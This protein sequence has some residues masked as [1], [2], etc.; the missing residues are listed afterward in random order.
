MSGLRMGGI[1]LAIVGVVGVGV[2]GV[3][4]FLS[5]QAKS[6]ID[7]AAT[8]AQGQVTGITQKDAY[9]LDA[10]VRTDATI[11]NLGFVLGGALVGTGVVLFLVGG[12]ASPSSVSLAPVGNGVV[13]S[14]TW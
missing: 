12:S 1:A 2:G 14:G 9:A 5:N 11:A 4:G 13:F 8:N 3:F 6:K 10:T 7:N